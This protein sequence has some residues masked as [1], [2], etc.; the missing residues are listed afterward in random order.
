MRRR[1]CHRSRSKGPSTRPGFQ[2]YRNRS[3]N[4]TRR[5]TTRVTERVHQNQRRVRRRV[6]RYGHTGKRRDGNDIAFSLNILSNVRRRS[7]TNRDRNRHRQRVIKRSRRNHGNR[8][9][10]H[11]VEGTVSSGEGPFRRRHRTRRQEA[12]NGRGTRSRHVTSG[13]VIPMGS[14]LFRRIRATPPFPTTG[15]HPYK[16][17]ECTS[18]IPGGVIS[19]A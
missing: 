3:Q 4:E 6:T 17:Y 14:R 5:N 13:K 11:R 7:Y 15:D 10:R 12:R 8:T 9:T 1:R 2:F 16:L 19:P 18:H